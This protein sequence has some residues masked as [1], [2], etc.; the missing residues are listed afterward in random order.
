M[1][2]DFFVPISTVEIG[3][4]LKEIKESVT[5]NIKKVTLRT[6]VAYNQDHSGELQGSLGVAFLADPALQKYNFLDQL[7]SMHGINT[8]CIHYTA[9]SNSNNEYDY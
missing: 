2:V 6:F 1:D 7:K 4:D 8:R 5:T 9:R 3:D